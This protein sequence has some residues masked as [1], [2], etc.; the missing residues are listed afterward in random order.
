[1]LEVLDLPQ[2]RQTFDFKTQT[3]LVLTLYLESFF[4][5]NSFSKTL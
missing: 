3:K 5:S 4:Y 1:M 2:P